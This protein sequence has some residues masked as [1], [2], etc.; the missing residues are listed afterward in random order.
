M[1]HFVI[2]FLHQLS[3]LV[4]SPS[5]SLITSEQIDNSNFSYAS[6]LLDSFIQYVDDIEWFE[7]LHGRLLIAT[8]PEAG[9]ELIQQLAHQAL[10]NQDLEFNLELLAQMVQEGDEKLFMKLAKASIPLLKEEV[11]FQDLITLTADYFG[12]LDDDDKEEALNALLNKRTKIRIN[13][14]FKQ[15]DADAATFLKIVK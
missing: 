1:T 15:S 6:E 2:D 5:N 10:K 12:C 4:Q 7:F 8:D 14:A 3:F 9:E 13:A 11:D